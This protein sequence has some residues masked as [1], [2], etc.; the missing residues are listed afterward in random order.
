M[1][2]LQPVGSG[3]AAGNASRGFG[4]FAGVFTPSILTILGVILYL[5]TGWVVGS[6]GLAG[7]LLIVGVSH[8]ISLSTGLSVASIA[9]NRTVR[10]GG[11]YYMISRSFGAQTGVAIG[12]P[13]F[14]AQALSTTFYIVGFTEALALL[15]PG[16]DRR[17]IGS[18]VLILI[19]AA[20]F[21]STSLAIRLQYVTMTMIALSLLSFFLGK[22][23]GPSAG[24]SWFGSGDATFT[25]VFAVF[26]PAV[27][28]ILAGV[29]MSGDLRN[30]DKALPRGTILAIFAGLC[31]YIAVPV[32]MAL[33]ASAVDLV[34]NK[35]SMWSISRFP[36]LIYVGVWGATL[37]SALG[38]ILGA[39]RTLQAISRDGMAP[40]IF[41]RGRGSSGEPAAATIFTFLLAEAG[42]LLGSLDVIAPILTMFFLAAYGVTNLACGLERW[43]STPSFRPVFKV[44]AWVSLLG[45]L[46]CFYVMSIIHFGAML[47]ALFFC[48]GIFVYAK[49]KSYGDSWSDARH[50][51]WAALVR[52]AVLR[53]RDARYHPA[54]WRPN[55]LIFGGDPHKRGHLLELGATIV[56]N[57]GTVS[58]VCLLEGGVVELAAQRVEISRDMEALLEEKFPSV[59]SKVDI[60]ADIFSDIVTIAQSY[61]I[62]PFEANTI[63][64]G[65]ESKRER[66]GR[67]TNMLKELTALDNSLLLVNRQPVG[68]PGRRERIDVWWGGLKGNGGLILLVAYLLKSHEDWKDATVRVTIVVDTHKNIPQ[69]TSNLTAL[70]KEARIE[71]EPRVIPKNG[72]TIQEVMRETGGDADIAVMGLGLPG[73]DDPPE[74]F[75][76]RTQAILD[77]LP[78]T[79]MVYSARHFESEPVLFDE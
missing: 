72:R 54:N 37:S 57:H 28:G 71:A 21:R 33:N 62:G 30:P 12:I 3:D 75:F 10:A 40:A 18:M 17:L 46:A 25:H 4:T 31:V 39:P 67:Y 19:T 76:D 8:L 73:D 58:Y 29:S 22:G 61:G 24:I 60:A 53:L 7:A 26:F 69:I 64:L 38:S 6:V 74:R 47:A 36:V 50:G 35:Y 34:Q 63:M 77:A 5:R 66:S 79:I 48:L 56:Q 9:T 49:R 70:L 1:I 45:A 52:T 27:T 42:I 43:A 59:L 13:L 15:I 32:W 68:E 14:F 23:S 51:I 41:G 2:Q 78:T 16:L 20:A 65:W 44:P 11:A 55:L